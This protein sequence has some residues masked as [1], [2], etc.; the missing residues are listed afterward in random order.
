M[1]W[2]CDHKYIGLVRSYDHENIIWAQAIV[3]VLVLWAQSYRFGVVYVWGWCEHKHIWGCDHKHISL[4]L[5]W[6]Q[7]YQFGSM[8]TIV[9]VWCCTQ[10]VHKHI[11]L[12]LWAQLYRLSTDISISVWCGDHNRMGLVLQVQAY[13]TGVV[14]TNISVWCYDHNGIDMVLWEQIYQLECREH[15]HF[16]LERWVQ[17]H[18]LVWWCEH[19]HIGL[20]LWTQT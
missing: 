4:V 16:S 10:L 13:Q 15:N 2:C 12:V 7:T 3:S 1:V 8:N 11:S 17:A 6:A 5:W 19:K 14:I 18:W 20:V 9:S